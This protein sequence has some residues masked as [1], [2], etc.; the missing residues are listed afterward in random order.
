MLPPPS[1]KVELTISDIADYVGQQDYVGKHTSTHAVVHNNNF[2]GIASYNIFTGIYVATIFGSAFF[3]DLFWPERMESRAVR[4][5]WRIC[6]VFACMLTLAGAIAFTYILATQSAYVTG[7]DPA[8]A[9]RV[10]LEYDGGPLQYRKNGRGIASV[11][12]LW[13]GMLATI[14]STVLLWHSL[15]HIGRHGPMSTHARTNES[16]AKKPARAEKPHTDGT[17]EAAVDSS[18]PSTVTETQGSPP[19]GPG[20][21]PRTTTSTPLHTG[22]TT[23]TS[24]TVAPPYSERP[25]DKA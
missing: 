18:S 9:R 3:F 20:T 10:L 5:A 21:G 14:A 13:P 16:V 2:I 7:T 17:S 19:D 8:T 11:A 4:L 23:G 22:T 15:K 1:V 12:F 24:T 25:L 6:S